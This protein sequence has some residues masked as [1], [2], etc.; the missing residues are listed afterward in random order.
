MLIEKY[1]DYEFVN[2]YG[3]VPLENIKISDY[4]IFI[5]CSKFEGSPN[6]TIEAITS[7]L[8]TLIA[9]NLKYT[10]PSSIQNL[11]KTYIQNDSASFQE[12]LMILLEK[13]SNLEIEIR[14]TFDQNVNLWESTIHELN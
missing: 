9:D 13:T 11:P 4:K 14:P 10:L 6:S 2:F 5:N 8:L 3:F 12:N 1:K 7:G